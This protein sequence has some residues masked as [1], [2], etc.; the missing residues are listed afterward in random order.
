VLIFELIIIMGEPEFMTTQPA[1]PAASG[2]DVMLVV[3][4]LGG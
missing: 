2:Q 4:L 1:E 3:V